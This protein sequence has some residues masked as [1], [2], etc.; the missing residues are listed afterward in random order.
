MSHLQTETPYYQPEQN[1]GLLVYSPGEGGF[2]N[3]PTFSDCSAANCVSSWA[4]RIINSANIY[5]Y[6]MGFYSFFQNFQLGCGNAQTCQERIIQTDYVGS[7]FLYNIF[8][9]G[10]EE[11][12]SPAA[13]LPAAVY[14]NDSNQN[15]YTSEVAAWLAL[16]DPSAAELG[17]G[18]DSDSGI[19]SGIVYIAPQIW[20]EPQASRT[21][22]CVPPCTLVLPPLTLSFPTTISFPPW[23]TTL[24]VGWTTTA[25][26]TNG[27]ITSV[28]TFY[29]TIS[30]STVLTVPPL[31][32]SIIDIWNTII[33]V[34]VTSTIIYPTSSV[35]PPSMVITDNP[36]PLSQPSVTHPPRNRT[37]YPPPWPW[38]SAIVYST[39]T[40]PSTTST[41][42][43][44]SSTTH[45]PLLPP[46]TFTTGKPKPTCAAGCGTRCRYW[47]TRCDPNVPYWLGGCKSSDFCDDDCPPGTTPGNGK[48]DISRN[49]SDLHSYKRV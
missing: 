10:A 29:T 44:T 18:G 26:L 7:A 47:C 33:P 9:Y 17:D 40:G 45:D 27:T 20:S 28:S 25:T 30:E 34:N 12:I 22:A 39:E 8:T 48:S 32:T 14:F 24:E 15:G 19:G 3:D 41:V 6:S 1:W 16:A 5:M 4:L 46:V 49:V 31:T 37:I 13:G 21:I 38:L 42:F 43:T 23:T 11:I 36:N 35:L 2:S